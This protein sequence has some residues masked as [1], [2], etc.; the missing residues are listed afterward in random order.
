MEKPNDL[1]F[2]P[3]GEEGRGDGIGLGSHNRYFNDKHNNEPC[4]GPLSGIT[5]LFA[6]GEDV[7]HHSPSEVENTKF[8]EKLRFVKSFVGI[9]AILTEFVVDFTKFHI[10]EDIVCLLDF[11]EFF[12]SVGAFVF[13]GVEGEGKSFVGAFDFEWV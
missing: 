11:V 13:V 1:V 12:G 2:S 6:E 8:H 10:H 5:R 7:S 4:E 9:D 3:S